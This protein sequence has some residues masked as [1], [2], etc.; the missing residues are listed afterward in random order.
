[1]IERLLAL[2]TTTFVKRASVQAL[3]SL[4]KLAKLCS[5]SAG[6]RLFEVGR[7]AL[8]LHILVAGSVRVE[9]LEPTVNVQF[10]PVR[11]VAGLAA[12]GYE[13]HRYQATAEVDCATL[14]ITKE[15]LFDVAE[16]HFSLAR[17]IFAYSSLERERIM[18]LR[19][20][21]SAVALAAQSA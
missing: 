11:L 2:R 14:A 18:K 1:M 21:R 19:Q 4:A 16:D 12:L 15:D 5:F 9:R 8:D 6:E 20:E 10:L 17:A 3:A 13:H 7:P